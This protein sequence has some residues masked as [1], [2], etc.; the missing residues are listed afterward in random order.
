MRQLKVAA[1][2]VG[3]FASGAAFGVEYTMS[4]E[5]ALASNDRAVT[6]EARARYANFAGSCLG[7]V[8]RDG[9]LYLHTEM[10]VR[11][12]SGRKVTLYLP[13]SDETIEV[14]PAINR[15][16]IGDSSVPVRD[17]NRGQSLN[18]YVNVNQITAPVVREVVFAVDHDD[19]A[20]TADDLM[21]VPA[22]EVA[23][24][25]TTG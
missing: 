8:E 4:C 10:I 5:D 15:I 16:K 14:T 21:A 1:A 20:E 23:A 22:D 11:R 2:A 6:D 24:L 13:A 3:I 12:V 18:L 9:E 25:P 17:L 7:A 19:D